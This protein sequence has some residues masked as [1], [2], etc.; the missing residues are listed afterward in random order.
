ML[1][2]YNTQL[3][4][5]VRL[6]L[7][8]LLCRVFGYNH[9]KTHTQPDSIYDGGGTRELLPIKYVRVESQMGPLVYTLLHQSANMLQVHSGVL[10]AAKTARLA[11][12]T[13]RFRG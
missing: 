3:Y 11:A 10:K 1:C 12:K 5:I 13:A 7:T 4:T 6:G 9:L 2:L 8:L